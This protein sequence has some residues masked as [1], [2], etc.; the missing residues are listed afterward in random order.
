LIPSARHRLAAAIFTKTS[1]SSSVP[2]FPALA[3][4]AAIAVFLLGDDD[5]VD[6]SLVSNLLASTLAYHHHRASFIG[7]IRTSRCTLLR[8]LSPMVA[9]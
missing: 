9:P 4:D 6:F 8:F 1:S 5:S 2:R 7:E 3:I